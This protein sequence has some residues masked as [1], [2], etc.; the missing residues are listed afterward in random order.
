MAYLIDHKENFKKGT[1]HDVYWF[2]GYENK[3]SKNF[4]TERGARNFIRSK[5]TQNPNYRLCKDWK[6]FTPRVGFYG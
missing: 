6:Y 1:G 3:L 4:K 2:T 5:L